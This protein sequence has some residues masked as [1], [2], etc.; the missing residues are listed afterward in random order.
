MVRTFGLTLGAG[1]FA[2]PRAAGW[3][4][5]ALASGAHG[6]L[7]AGARLFALVPGS[8]VW[9]PGDVPLT[10]H[11]R[12]RAEIRIAYLRAGRV[13]RPPAG[14]EALQ[15]GPLLQALVARAIDRGAFDGR[16]AG[17][18]RLAAV[19]FDEVALARPAALSLPLPEAR[20][21]RTVAERLMAEPWLRLGTAEL[22]RDAGC[23]PRTLER[24]FATELGLGVAAWQRK[25][26]LLHGLAILAA[27]ESVT[28]AGLDAGY[29]GLSAFIAAFRRE[30]GAS[31]RRFLK[32]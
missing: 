15:A 7:R 31:P 13:R 18:R 16:R 29:A 23:S 24:A 12:R 20:P 32:R 4:V 10:F 19:L 30:F 17:E 25:L 14:V 5:L 6:A 11:L 26:R 3:D 27:G 8:A 28:D 1:T 22:A 21:A 9:I 2:P